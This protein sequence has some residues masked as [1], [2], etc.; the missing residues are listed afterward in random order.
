MLLGQPVETNWPTA[1]T[2]LRGPSAREGETAQQ[3]VSPRP[4]SAWP[5]EAERPAGAAR[6]AAGDHLRPRQRK[7]A[8]AGGSRGI[9]E[10]EPVA[11]QG[12]EGEE[13]GVPRRPSA[14]APWPSGA[15]R[16]EAHSGFGRRRKRERGWKEGEAELWARAIG[17]WRGGAGARRRRSCGRGERRARALGSGGEETQAGVS[18]RAGT[19]R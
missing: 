19:S 2:G 8:S 14:A 15:R 3:G 5:A 4:G 1:T 18:E 10:C 6:P 7:Q 9:G 17:E 16:G 11:K 12:G 13:G